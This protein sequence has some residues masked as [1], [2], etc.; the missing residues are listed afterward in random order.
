VK[1][2]RVL[3]AVVVAAIAFPLVPAGDGSVSA[4][5]PVE[6]FRWS[7]SGPI[8]RFTGAAISKDGGTAFAVI[9]RSY[10][11][12]PPARGHRSANG[13]ATWDEMTSMPERY[14]QAVDT[15]AT[16]QVVFASGF[17]VG[18]SSGLDDAVFRSTDS[19]TTWVSVLDDT[20]SPSDYFGDVGVSDNGMKVVVATSNGLRLSTD[21]GQTWTT[22]NG[23]DFSAAD[24]S[25]DGSVIMAARRNQTIVKSVNGGTSWT[26]VYGTSRNWS[27]VHLS[28]DGQSAAIV[29]TRNDPIAGGLYFTHDGGGN[30][31]DAGL[32]PTFRDSQYAIGAMSP[33]G[34][35]MIASSYYTLP[36]VSVDGGATWAA[37]PSNIANRITEGWTNFAISDPDSTSALNSVE[38][39]IIGVTESHRIARFGFRSAP[40]VTGVNANRGRV[41]GGRTVTIS[42]LDFTGATAVSFGGTPATSFTVIDDSS[43]SAVTPAHAGGAVNVTVSNSMGTSSDAVSFLY[44]DTPAPVITAVT[45]SSI[46]TAGLSEIQLTGTG[47]E[48]ILDV[49]VNGQ[50][51]AE[52]GLRNSNTLTVLVNELPAGPAT[53]L[54]TTE[55]GEARIDINFDPAFNPPARRYTE[56][57]SFNAAGL[58]NQ[59]VTD[60]GERSDGSVIAVGSFQDAGNVATADCVAVWDGVSWSGLGSDGSGNGAID[61]DQSTG[62]QVMEVLVAQDGHVF[63]RGSFTLRGSPNEY[64]VAEFD[65]TRWRGLL[66]YGQFG[67]N[68]N[69]LAGFSSSRIYIGGGFYDLGGIVDCNSVA[70][71]NGST[72]SCPGSSPGAPVFNDSVTRIAVAPS[73]NVYAIGYFTD[74]GG[75]ANADHLVKWDGAAWTAVGDDGAGG[76]VIGASMRADSITVS[77]A[78][79][80]DMVIVSMVTDS[81]SDVVKPTVKRYF[82]GVWTTEISEPW[83]TGVS[84]MWL[85][86]NGT[87][88]ASG[89]IGD[90]ATHGLNALGYLRQGKWH[91]FAL[92][93][94][95][96]TQSYYINTA[97]ALSDGRV[98]VSRVVANGQGYSSAQWQILI[99]DPV[100]DPVT[101]TAVPQLPATGRGVPASLAAVLVFI[102]CA[103][104]LMR[105][106]RV[107]AR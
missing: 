49:T 92:E 54:V 76:P 4:T 65:G 53:V 44:L 32:S 70:L 90:S 52:F 81:Y 79:G 42:G 69:S 101:T 20:A 27:T 28:T 64:A 57:T 7:V 21:Q 105:R 56:I 39:R 26:T 10:V 72:W 74:A 38:P 61:C 13:G 99:F 104:M 17:V 6:P 58:T 55:T 75:V 43:I 77:E 62:Y 93:T 68:V 16:G 33:D 67:G 5:A 11:N 50:S 84:E 45:P 23:G 40:S 12:N 100:E 66:E 30:W 18:Q 19:G 94:A 63:V 24:I 46:G 8:T 80:L 87:L 3:A 51:A 9:D 97:F 106:Y 73:G 1:L 2:H 78:Y 29:A 25:G 48:N 96:A 31:T 41:S 14:W 102:G 47:F 107:T 91:A 35:T 34:N 15:S 85:L 98:I 60:F 71:W 88:L 22:V 103:I 83:V 36:R 37:L 95:F 59:V 82:G 89:I 86:G